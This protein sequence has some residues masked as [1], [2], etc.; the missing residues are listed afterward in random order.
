MITADPKSSSARP[1]SQE[2][3]KQPLSACICTALERYFDDLDGH[4]PPD[5]LYE[6]VMDEV[7]YPLLKKVMHYARGNQSRAAAILG[8]NRGTLRKRLEKHGLL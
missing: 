5:N 6:L 1:G 7:E 3:R 8:I 2:R 4:P